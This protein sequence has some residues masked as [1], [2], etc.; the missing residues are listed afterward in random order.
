MLRHEDKER[1]MQRAKSNSLDGQ[2]EKI[3]FSHMR[4]YGTRE[5]IRFRKKS[6]EQLKAFF[7]HSNVGD[8]CLHLAA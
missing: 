4:D 2:D 8:T 3:T 6:S 7:G 1:E 5:S